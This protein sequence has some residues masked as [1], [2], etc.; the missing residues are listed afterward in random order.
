MTCQILELLVNTF[1]TDEKYSVLIR[2]NLTIPIQMQLSEKH[3][4]FSQLFA[5]FET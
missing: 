5:V 4:Y 2:D 1:A 3:K